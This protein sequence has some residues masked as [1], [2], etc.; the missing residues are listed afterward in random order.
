MNRLSMRLGSTE[1]THRSV[2]IRQYHSSV[3]TAS[4]V[5]TVTIN[6]CPNILNWHLYTVQPWRLIDDPQDYTTPL[7]ENE[8]TVYSAY[9]SWSKDRCSH[10]ALICSST[11]YRTSEGN[12]E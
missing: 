2:R 10:S 7:Y 1:Q 11:S 12:A 8:L 6:I 5:I 4:C 3:I 9:I